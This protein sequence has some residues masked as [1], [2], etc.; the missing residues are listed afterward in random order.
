MLFHD[1]LDIKL[2]RLVRENP[3]LYDHNNAKYMDFNMREVTWQKIG[4][5]LKRSA[6][7][8]KVRWINI[9]DV[10][11]RIL[12]KNLEPGQRP[13]MYKYESEVSFLRPFYKD[14]TLQNE[15]FESDDRS[16]DQGNDDHGDDGA[17]N[18]DNSDVPDKKPKIKSY[19]KSSVKKKKKRRNYEEAID[20]MSTP[21]LNDPASQSEF[22]STD[23][24]DAFLLSIGATLR[25]FS[26]YHLNLAKSKI[27][28][29]VQEHDLQQIVEKNQHNETTPHD[30]KI[31]SSESIYMQ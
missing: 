15:E 20:P 5:D 7:D 14:V 12:R 6:A 13:K 1:K 24:V 8:C 2:I 31:T 16:N 22:D 19:Y 30:I 29:V 10:Y 21:T 18:S 28:S 9:R 3:V 4:D 23:P 11:R 26:P 27:F 25:T 17:N